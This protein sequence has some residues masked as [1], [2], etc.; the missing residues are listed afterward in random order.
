MRFDEEPEHLAE[1][2]FLDPSRARSLIASLRKGRADLSGVPPAM[3]LTIGRIIGGIGMARGDSARST[4]PRRIPRE[5]NDRN[6]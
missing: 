3:A 1:T 6:D 4:G 2:D 5:R